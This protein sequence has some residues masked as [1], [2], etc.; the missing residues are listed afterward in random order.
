[1]TFVRLNYLV[2]KNSSR[3]ISS[4]SQF[5]QKPQFLLYVSYSNEHHR[6]ESTD[7]TRFTFCK[8]DFY[9]YFLNFFSPLIFSKK[10]LYPVIRKIVFFFR[11]DLFVPSSHLPGYPIRLTIPQVTI[12]FRQKRKEFFSEKPRIWKNRA[13]EQV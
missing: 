6:P 11:P 10:G 7:P 13:L 8:L 2:K 5:F 3:K 1:M 4:P 12:K 9:F